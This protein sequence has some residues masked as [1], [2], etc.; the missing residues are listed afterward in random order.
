MEGLGGEDGDSGV[1]PVLL[2]TVHYVNG[3]F[4]YYDGL[5]TPKK[6]FRTAFP[7]DFKQETL[8]V[9]HILYVK[10]FNNAKI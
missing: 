5:N 3:Q 4:V 7:T 2:S 1:D 10:I 9:D 8:Y 6:K